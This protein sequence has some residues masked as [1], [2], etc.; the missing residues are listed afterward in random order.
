MK[1]GATGQGTAENVARSFA[2]ST[3]ALAALVSLFVWGPRSD[4]L[5]YLSQVTAL[6]VLA[7]VALWPK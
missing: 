1:R 2:L 4:V 7:V 3:V 6:L 5:N